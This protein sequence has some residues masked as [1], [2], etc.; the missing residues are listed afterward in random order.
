MTL[1]ARLV[2]LQIRGGEAR[3]LFSTAGDKEEGVRT[4]HVRAHQ[5]YRPWF[6]A[7]TK[8][9][10]T[11]ADT[12]ANA[13]EQ[14]KESA[15]EA[16]YYLR[17]HPHV[18]K[19]DVEHKY[20]SIF[21]SEKTAV[22]KVTADS[23]RHF[24]DVIADAWKVPGVVE[25]LETK[26]PHSVKFSL[27]QGLSFFCTADIA[28]APDGTLARMRFE[29]EE[30]EGLEEVRVAVIG[31]EKDGLKLVSEF[32][33]QT[34]NRNEMDAALR[35][36]QVDV[37]FSYGGD[38]FLQGIPGS[39][40]SPMG[41]FL[42]ACV[43]VDVKTDLSADIYHEGK[44]PETERAW[45]QFARQRLA[46]IVEL[47]QVSGAPPEMVCRVSPGRLNTYLHVAAAQEN[48]VLVP[49]LKK[50]SENP[51]TMS[52]LR[53]A[54]RGGTIFYPLPG[55]Y[56]NVAKMDFSS[57]YPSIIVNYNISPE[58]LDFA[59]ERLPQVWTP[60]S[61]QRKGLIAHGIEKVLVRRL[62]LK[63]AMK[64]AAKRG[65][66]PLRQELDARQRALKNILVT[67]FGYL[68]FNNFVFSNVECKESVM[69][70]GRVLLGQAKEMAEEMGL[71]VVYG[72]V[73]S[74]FLQGGTRQ[75]YE[76]YRR[77]ASKELAIPLELE[78]IFKRIV[79]PASRSGA[80]VANKY[81]GVFENGKLEA[82][83]IQWRHKDAC[84]LVKKFQEQAA[85]A[86]L[87]KPWKEC[88]PE[89]KEKAKTWAE[90][91]GR[92]EN[93]RAGDW[94]LGDYAIKTRLRKPLEEYSSNAAHVRAAREAARTGIEFEGRFVHTV[95]GAVPL[96]RAKPEEIDR[97]QYRYL[98]SE[99]VEELIRGNFV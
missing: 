52:Q 50:F 87:E 83:G 54:D 70:A 35:A 84:G 62:Q 55:V 13:P 5:T 90:G 95:H 44:L 6:Y 29:S 42:D 2:N 40:A 92:A 71:S 53:R 65:N 18:Y 26:I 56:E 28:V 16:A 66:E 34:L 73:D 1:K 94:P 58:T 4:L 20:A 37:A 21:D 41:V 14:Q 93:E 45:L 15:E 32:G 46:R 24:R 78:G 64:E 85:Y 17:Q 7:R 39:S 57:M 30:K 69:F 72:V 51:K 43:H 96:S 47:S 98:L 27:A 76:E 12:E 10:A 99:A 74:I 80:G 88:V 67:C 49:D 59:G 60:Q 75:Q 91:Y 31:K 25:L 8:R 9:P 68:G 97:L 63:A 82:R 79:F 86:L 48:G 38:A 89:L 23:T 19:A 81:Y 3:M 61:T 22:V 11:A 33:T 36:Q 77:R